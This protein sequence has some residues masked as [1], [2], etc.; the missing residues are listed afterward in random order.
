MGVVFSIEEVLAAE[1]DEIHGKGWRT[2]LTLRNQDALQPRAWLN[3]DDRDSTRLPAGEKEDR[4]KL[5][6]ALNKLNRAALCFSGGG[7]RSAAFCLGV[8]QALADYDVTRHEQ[9]PHH[10]APTGPS[11]Q[12]STSTHSGGESAEAAPLKPKKPEIKPKIKSENSFLGCFDYLS[13]VS[14]GGYVGS[15]LSSWRTREDFPAVIRKLT[16]RPDGADVEPPE[17]SWLR[18]YSNYLTPR[19][20]IASADSWAAVAICVRNL[21]LNWLVII[22]VVCLV[23]LALKIIATLGVRIAHFGSDPFKMV[24][25]LMLGVA[26]LIVAQ[27]FTNRYRP[28][29]RAKQDIVY[30]QSFL[31]FDFLWAFISAILLTIFLA[32]HYASEHIFAETSVTPDWVR[33]AT[34][35]THLPLVNWLGFRT[36][37]LLLMAGSGFLIYLIGWIAGRRLRDG[38]PDF[39][40]WS[41]SG[42]VYGALVGAGA[43]LLDWFEPYKNWPSFEQNEWYLLIPIIFGV[44]WVLMS[45]LTADNIFV[46]LAS[47][48]PLSDSDREWLGRAAGWL[49]AGAIAWAATAFLV[50]AGGYFVQGGERLGRPR[51][52]SCRRPNRHPLRHRHCISWQQFRDCG[53]GNKQ[54]PGRWNRQGV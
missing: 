50:F 24:L 11:S 29:R 53:K 40:Y 18:A 10:G 34:G 52:P 25:V 26:C 15:W 22:P 30:E 2:E 3:A 4:E 38:W 33:L 8:L 12:L 13:T 41:V 36:T 7:I 54:R 37:L 45:Q 32:S 42:L 5:Y 9:K 1:A 19:V 51:N 21:I 44:P 46:G 27:S 43:Y 6:R 28:S 35:W 49:A 39:M 31:A 17:I 14:G 47:Y 23:L 16:S 48:E 20:G